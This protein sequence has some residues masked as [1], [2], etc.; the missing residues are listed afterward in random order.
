LFGQ[1]QFHFFAWLPFLPFVALFFLGLSP[2]IAE[3]HSALNHFW[4]CSYFCNP[5]ILHSSQAAELVT[6]KV[7][8]Q[9]FFSLWKLFR[10]I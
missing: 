10:I 4:W 2:E 8:F 5:V 3:I 9:P 1:A 6:F 7:K